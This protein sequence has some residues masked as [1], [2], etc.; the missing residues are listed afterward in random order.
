MPPYYYSSEQDSSTSFDS[1]PSDYGHST[2]FDEQY[3]GQ[4]IDRN[5]EE[6]DHH[7]QSYHN[8]PADK[9]K[10][11][12]TPIQTLSAS[13]LFGASD[14]R[15]RPTHVSLCITV[16]VCRPEHTKSKLRYS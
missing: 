3:Q 2:Q 1:Y 13:V 6:S 12:M 4:E 8:E 16:C 14:Q 9:S 11:N 5:L 10:V 7:Q 15:T